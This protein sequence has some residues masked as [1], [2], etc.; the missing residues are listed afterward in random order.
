MIRA[1]AWI[2]ARAQWALAIGVLTAFFVPGP[3]KLLDGTIPFWVA[4]LTGLAMTRIDLRAVASR[5]LTPRR[6]VRN[7]ALLLVLMSVTPALFAGLGWLFGLDDTVVT[8]LVYTASAPPLGSATAFCLMLGFNAAFA[9]EITVLGSFLAP[10]T[11]PLVSRLLLGEAV[12]IDVA[13]MTLRLAL[14]IGCAALGA[15]I[16]RRVIGAAAI[17][18]HGHTFDGF[19]VLCL[20]LFLFPL[21]LGLREQ[22]AMAPLFAALIMGLV[23]FT[24]LGMQILTLPLCRAV[25]GPETG[26][27]TALIW[28]NRNAALSLAAVPG[29]P[30]LTLY[31]SLYQFPMYLTPLIMRPIAGVKRPTSQE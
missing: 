18:R 15:V 1:L 17:D 8:V 22:I 9:L 19:A 24:N 25:A 11:M 7:T 4:L 26:G 3:G 12:P 21:F 16:A 28:G 13:E 6:L 31:V 23:I 29:D 5:A 14:L 27:A 10:F 30:V 20:V 2:G